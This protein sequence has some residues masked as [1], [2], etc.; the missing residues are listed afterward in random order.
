MTPTPVDA[1]VAAASD[2]CDGEDDALA[3]AL[4]AACVELGCVRDHESSVRLLAI[5][6]TGTVAMGTSLTTS[7]SACEIRQQ[8][9]SYAAATP[10]A[11]SGEDCP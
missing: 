8:E 10:A 3:V 7:W 5:L 11:C 1:V 4:E 9:A 2:D 6:A